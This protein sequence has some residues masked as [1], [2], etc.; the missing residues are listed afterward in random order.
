M[1]RIACS[2]VLRHG[3]DNNPAEGGRIIVQGRTP[4]VGRVT[5]GVEQVF[6]DCLINMA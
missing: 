1:H 3:L 5:D 6:R 4:A 2:E